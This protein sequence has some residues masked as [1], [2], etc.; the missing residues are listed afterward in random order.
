MHCYQR[1]HGKQVL[2][3]LDLVNTP[4]CNMSHIY[5]NNNSLKN[6]LKKPITGLNYKNQGNAGGRQM[7]IN[8]EPEVIDDDVSQISMTP[9]ERVKTMAIEQKGQYFE[10]FLRSDEIWKKYKAQQRR[11]SEAYGNRV[12]MTTTGYCIIPRGQPG[13]ELDRP[14]N[15]YQLF[16]RVP[17]IDYTTRAVRKLEVGDTR[18]RADVTVTLTECKIF[19]HSKL[20]NT[21][22]A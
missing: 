17:I 21:R 3:F 11:I 20:Q 1:A 15:V 22:S 18:V 10:N 4:K 16:A 2:E 14:V 19:F 8:N 6:I 13:Y 12:D 5:A 9:Q 7:T